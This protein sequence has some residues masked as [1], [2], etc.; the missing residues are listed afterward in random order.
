MRVNETATKKN[1][2][3]WYYLK[4]SN[5]IEKRWERN[6]IVWKTKKIC[7]LLLFF[8][9][10][11]FCKIVGFQRTA[12]KVAKMLV[13]LRDEE[14][15]L[16]PSENVMKINCMY[17]WKVIWYGKSS[18]KNT[19]KQIKRICFTNHRNFN[20]SQIIPTRNN[21]KK[22]PRSM[23]GYCTWK[24]IT[25]GLIVYE[26]SDRSKVTTSLLRRKRKK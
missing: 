12:L 18:N 24:K 25:L 13:V 9:C 15:S 11:L 22:L 23:W 5:F 19:D 1:R 4:N 17:I 26:S 21:K 16:T 8:F 6:V 2:C 10:F 20:Q 3:R 14:P 7:G